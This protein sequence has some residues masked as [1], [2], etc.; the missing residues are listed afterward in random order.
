M[1][2]LLLA[3]PMTGAERYG[4]LSRAGTYLPPLGL[5]YLAAAVRHRHEVRILDAE[6][7]GLGT[8]SVID[9][10]DRW[11]PDLVGITVVTPALARVEAIC[12]EVKARRPAT[13]VVVGGPYP[14][15]CPLETLACQAVDVAVLGEGEFTFRELL[16][17]VEAGRPLRDVAGLA[18]RNDGRPMLTAPRPRILDLDPLPWPA[19]DLL[20]MERYRPSPLHHRELPA[21]SVVCG[22]GCPWRCTFC[23][24]AKVF[25]GRFTVRTPEAVAA[26]VR[27][28]VAEQGAREILFWDD[29]FGLTRAW[30]LRLCELLAPLG[31]A[32][33]AWMRVDLAEP[34]VL[35]AMARA[36][37]WHVSYGVESGNQTVLDGIRKGFRVQDV[38][39][40]FR[41]TR[42]AGLEARGT[43]VLGLPGDTWDTMMET[44]DLAIEVRADFAQFQYLTPYPGTELWDDLARHGE[45]L[46][47]DPA[48]HTIWFPVFVPHGVTEV[49]LRAAHRLA[50]RRFYLRPRYL[51]DRLLGLRSPGDLARHVRGARAVLEYTWP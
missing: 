25:H 24:C 49:Q 1:R 23:S 2:V 6:A 36:G 19:R 48:T 7:M 35:R 22:R 50:H 40:A 38:R 43:F 12:H 10:I 21:F 41:W 33:S 31:V 51:L 3:P 39:D 44:I 20:P 15:A 16:E 13:L 45:R 37:C 30:T 4:G 17:A 34:D 26:E 14:S 5:A 46:T 27:A 29:T 47:T 9:E 28:L 32:W 18:L 42:E 11:A 8:A